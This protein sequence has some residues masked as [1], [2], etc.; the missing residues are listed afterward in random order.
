MFKILGT[1]ILGLAVAGSAHAA[2]NRYPAAFVTEA[3]RACVN[4]APSVPRATAM[5][6]CACVL[7]GLQAKYRLGDAVELL[8]QIKGSNMP[9]PL[10]PIVGACLLEVTADADETF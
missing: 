4:A 5:S 8:S 6:Y 1:L 3:V 9:R 2:S 7:D 10:R